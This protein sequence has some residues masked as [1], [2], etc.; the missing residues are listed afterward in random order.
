MAP[1]GCSLG[2]LGR[3]WDALVGSQERPW[4]RLGPQNACPR[5]LNASPG[6]PNACPGP[7]N[8]CP[9]P[10]NACP[11]RLN[12]CPGPR[13]A[14]GAQQEKTA[15]KATQTA[16]EQ[17]RQL[18]VPTELLSLYTSLSMDIDRSSLVYISIL[19]FRQEAPQLPKVLRLARAQ[20][21]LSC[22]ERLSK[23]SERLSLIHI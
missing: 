4:G 17:T 8:A 11:R 6:P 7:L 23:A 13:S 14:T 19:M 16:E 3:S 21:L 22:P 9:G 18:T 12:A 20:K 1:S 10:Q 2:G 15:D 5:P